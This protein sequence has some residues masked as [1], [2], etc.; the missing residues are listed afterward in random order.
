[1]C[2]VYGCIINGCKIEGKEG[3]V[4]VG[5]D[6]KTFSTFS[7]GPLEEPTENYYIAEFFMSCSV[8]C[9]NISNVKKWE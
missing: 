6:E 9:S 4:Q 8:V 3:Q 5:T 1:M 2:V 7:K